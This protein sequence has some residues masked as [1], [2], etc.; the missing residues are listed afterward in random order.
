[1]L[2]RSL[3]I[4]LI[5]FFSTTICAE[6]K[7]PFDLEDP[8]PFIMQPGSGLKGGYGDKTTP[9]AFRTNGDSEDVLTRHCRELLETADK[10][11][12]QGRPQR[13]WAALERY[14]YECQADFDRPMEK[15]P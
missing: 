15:V 1:M 14:K 10:F 5:T 8:K 11:K 7:Q 3:T 6:E 4:T 9:D 13:R 2:I 12:R